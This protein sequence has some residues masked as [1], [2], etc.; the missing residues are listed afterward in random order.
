MLL[1]LV[2]RLPRRIIVF[3]WAI[4]F[5][6]M[7]VPLG[8]N[9]S[10]SLMSLLSRLSAKTIV[11]YQPA[12]GVCF[13]MM[14]I[15]TAAQTYFPITYK[16]DLLEQVFHIASSIWFL[17]FVGIL[18]ILAA[19]YLRT[20]REAGTS[21]HLRENIYLSQNVTTPAVCGILRPKILLPLSFRDRD[22]EL[23]LLHEKN[24]IRRRDNLWRLL[25]TLLAAA[26]WFNPLSL[27]F[28]KL[29]LTDLE[30]SCDECVLTK[31]GDT[32]RKRYA[33]T[34]LDS[35]QNARI[36]SSGFGGAKLRPR[37]ERILSYRN[38][39]RFSL[40]AFSA[41]AAVISYILLTNA[42]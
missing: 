42:S 2:K 19:V 18:L 4:P 13:S 24:H 6:R 29:F 31:L 40:G 41:L 35:R 5:L 26:H 16:I 9:S 20:T 25:A 37:I 27:V 21:I 12:D 28:L 3:L 30:L 17:V 15:T 11:I 7:A 34:L 14:N 1:R 23:I 10:W 39:T 32:G 38:M 22:T 36:F 8:L 33:S